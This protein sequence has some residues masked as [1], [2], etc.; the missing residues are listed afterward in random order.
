MGTIWRPQTELNTGKKYQALLDAVLADIK[1]GVLSAGEKLPP[2]RQLAWEIGLTP[3]TV[4]RAYQEG[5]AQGALVAHTGQ[6]TFVADPETHATSKD[7][8]EMLFDP[9]SSVDLNAS[10]TCYVGQDRILAKAMRETLEESFATIT[11][12]PRRS[13]R[14]ELYRELANWITP[15]GV[16][17]NPENIVLTHGGQNALELSIRAILVDA[18]RKV[19]LDR[20]FYPGLRMAL[21]GAGADL[22]GVDIDAQGPVPEAVE[23]LCQREKIAALYTSANV[24]NPT[25]GT[26][27]LERRQ[28]LVALA[29]K[30]DFQIVEDDCWCIDP[31]DIPSFQQIVPERGWYL[32]SFSKS[33]AAGLRF[34]FLHAPEA[35]LPTLKRFIR[36]S[37]YG[38]GRPVADL[39]LEIL[40]SGAA[41]DIRKAVCAR[42]NARLALTINHLGRWDISWQKSVPFLWLRLPEGWRTASF[43]AA[44][45]RHGVIPRPADEFTFNDAGVP[46]AVRLSINCSVP[47]ARYIEALEVMNTILSETP[48]EFGA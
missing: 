28:A 44:C 46:A 35:Y 16:T 47:E 45:E 31:M 18:P 9:N 8:R 27:P 29:R 40:R 3:G 2:V 19:A 34:G 41:T 21:E 37:S 10:N 11:L 48:M 23:A 5:I 24:M 36:I 32:S 17:A 7:V 39:A 14:K 38:V 33:I 30:Y 12:Y 43:V 42:V 4:A 13:E 20:L 1:N 25:T 15:H 6:G 26:M 22:V